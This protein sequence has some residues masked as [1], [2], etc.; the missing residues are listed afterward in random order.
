M[1]YAIT[2]TGEAEAGLGVP[3][4]PSYLA[5]TCLNNSNRFQSQI[6]LCCVEHVVNS[7]NFLIQ[8]AVALRRNSE[9]SG[10]RTVFHL[11]SFSLQFRTFGIGW[12]WSND[13]YQPT[14]QFG[15]GWR[16]RPFMGRSKSRKL[17]QIPKQAHVGSG[18]TKLTNPD[19]Q[20]SWTLTF[21]TIGND[22]YQS[23]ALIIAETI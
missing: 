1:E 20:N 4:Q 7:L 15:A 6:K 14:A 8:L 12:Q 17:L 22:R 18:R 16:C 23:M 2:S 10:W 19:S 3:I 21:L 9:S 13:I 11:S 5:R